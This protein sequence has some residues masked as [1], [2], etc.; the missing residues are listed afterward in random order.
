M[1]E[2]QAL[3]T[4]YSFTVTVGEDYPE[5]LSELLQR[6]VSHAAPLPAWPPPCNWPAV[7]TM[8]G[9]AALLHIWDSLG[10]DPLAPRL[11][12]ERFHHKR[13]PLLREELTARFT[14][15][16]LTEQTNPAVG[17]EQQVDFLIRFTDSHGREVAAYQCSYRLPLATWQ[18]G[19]GRGTGG[20]GERRGR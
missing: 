7:A 10:V 2:R 1:I 17:V 16:D 12:R 15:E 9:T 3:G 18:R 8:H 4:V 6:H 13:E 11:I 19:R 14:V 20:R 5:G